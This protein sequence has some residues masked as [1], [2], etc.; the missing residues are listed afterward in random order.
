MIRI[1]LVIWLG[2]ISTCSKPEQSNNITEAEVRDILA[3]WETAYVTRDTAMMNDILHDEWI[4]A[5]SKDGSI[6]DKEASIYELANS[7]YAFL[8]MDFEDLDIKLYSDIAIARA[9]EVLSMQ[10]SNGDTVQIPLRFT[11]VY[12]KKNGQIKCLSTHSSPIEPEQ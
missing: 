5:G 10:L 3:R 11:D 1:Q 2:I 6:T 12:Q 4:Y 8:S 7:D 9:R